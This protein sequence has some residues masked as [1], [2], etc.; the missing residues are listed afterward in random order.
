MDYDV[1]VYDATSGGVISAVEAARQGATTALLCASWPA[2]YKEG[3]F[4]V[5]GMSASGLGQSDIGRAPDKVIGGLAL[6]FYRRN[7]AHYGAV[8]PSAHEESSGCRLPSSRCNV[9]YNLEPHVA[10]GIFEDMLAEAG[11]DVIW[12]ATVTRVVVSRERIISV[13]TRNVTDL[14]AKVFVDASYEGDLLALA[15]VSYTYGREANTTWNESL[16]GKRKGSHSHQFNVAI[17]PFDEK[18]DLL[19]FLSLPDSS[20]APGS[21]DSRIQAYNFRLCLTQNSSNAKPFTKP[22]GFSSSQFELLRRYLLACEGQNCQMGAP[23]CNNAPVP[24]GK[25]DMNNCGAFSSDFIG[26]SFSYPEASFIERQKIWHAHLQYTQGLL[27][28]LAN[29]TAS[30][31]KVRE[32][33]RHWGLCS[34]EFM[35]NLLAPHWPPWMYVREARR[36]QGDLVFTQNTPSQQMGRS[37]GDLS[38]GIGSYNFDSHNAERMAC[39]GVAR[40]F[41]QGPMGVSPSS[42]YAWNEGDVEVWPGFYQLPFWVMVPKRGEVDNLLVIAAPSASHIGMSTLRMEPQFMILGHAAG[43]AAAIT[44][45]NT[46]GSGVTPPVR[47]TNLTQLRS[48]LLGEGALLDILPTPHHSPVNYRTPSEVRHEHQDSRLD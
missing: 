47:D 4:R 6:E 42:S 21:G 34:D 2:C 22:P 11:V 27:W 40:C 15:G 13:D 20:A 7:R 23:S 30:P 32:E 19:P 5:G 8:P 10:R 35:D 46:S 41:G 14:H 26:G 29:D 18:G 16:A 36:M 43:A 31:V 24:H 9:T 45:R 1:I 44:V 3:G 38:V 39:H 17:D 25:T 48:T 37:I 12:G 33:M 28:F